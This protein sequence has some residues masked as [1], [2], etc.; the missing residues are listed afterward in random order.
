MDPGAA[1]REQA[2]EL[3]FSLAGL[4]RA[5]PADPL[6][7]MRAWL[8]AGCHGSMAWMESR[9]EERRDPR[10]LLPQAAS[11]LALGVF[12]EAGAD[13][14]PIAG[15][16]RVA[17]FA[18]GR[19][20]H[21]VLKKRLRKLRRAACELMPGLGTYASVDTGPVIERHWARAAGLGW[22]G[23][24]SG[25]VVP[26][27]G[28]WVL[29]ATL[30]MDRAIA[31][32]APLDEGCEECARC[33]DVC[34]TGAIVEPGVVDAR[35]CIAYLTIEERGPI[36]PGL[37]AALGSRFFGCDCCQEVC[38]HNGS[39]DPGDPA[40]APLPDRRDLDLARLLRLSGDAELSEWLRGS[41]IRRP[42]VVALKRNAALVLGNQGDRSAVPL[43]ASVLGQ[44]A[45]SLVRGH[46][47]WALG[48]LGGPAARRALGTAAAWEPDHEVVD[49]ILSAL[50]M[51]TCP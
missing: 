1:L 24:H 51:A 2:H 11:V 32:D 28:S 45:S 42:G 35:R 26:G 47:A 19:D 49:E 48:R 50:E 40:L 43:L 23:R 34:P 37:R 39:T 36:P 29:L 10:R 15:R 5:G 14:R 18:R 25:L 31:A 33:M 44:E 38:P 30:L 7:H 13:P 4:A 22:I 16:G 20:Y 46:A 21:G 27:R 8:D 41:P 3:G 12:Y 17:R 9:A 6:G